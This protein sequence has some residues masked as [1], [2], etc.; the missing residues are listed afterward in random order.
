VTLSEALDDVT[1]AAR[2]PGEPELFSVLFRRH[3]HDVHRF[4]RRRTGH[5]MLA[6]D[7]TALTFERCWKALPGFRPRGDS[8]R[9]WLMRIAANEMASH[10]RSESRRHRREQ[11][12]A[13]RDLPLVI[14][15]E[16]DLPDE[17]LVAALAKLDERHQTV[18]SMRFLADLTTEEAAEAM[19]VGRRHF[20]VL[21]YRA[22]GA[23]RRHL[24]GADD[25]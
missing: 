15:Q 16:H 2:A 4:I 14:G 12:A 19:Q 7:L 3:V 1:L 13:V 18:L 10:Y 23:L 21:Q 17:Q 20:A 5:D 8:L 22:L 6:D 25:A 11:L 9:P 24:E